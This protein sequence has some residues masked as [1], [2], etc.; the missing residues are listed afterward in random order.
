MTLR[1]K[2]PNARRISICVAEDAEDV[3]LFQMCHRQ[4]H[5]LDRG[6]HTDHYDFASRTSGIQA[7]L[8]ASFFPSTF[9]GNINAFIFLVIL[10]RWEWLRS[11]KN[12]CGEAF[13]VLELPLI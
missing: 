11:G 9:K 2:Q 3:N 10:E 8:H 4:W 13:G 12:I 5:C 6:S 1:R 7:C